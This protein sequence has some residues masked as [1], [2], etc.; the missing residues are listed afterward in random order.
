MKAILYNDLESY[1]AFSYPLSPLLNDILATIQF[2]IPNRMKILVAISE[3]VSFASQF[4]RNIQLP[5]GTGVPINA[6]SFCIAASGAH[7]DSS[8]RA[9]RKVF[10]QAYSFVEEQRETYAVDKAIQAAI[11]AGEELPETREVY[12]AYYQKPTPI[13]LKELT[14]Q[15]LVQYMNDIPVTAHLGAGVVVNS[16]L[17][18]E[19]NT[20]PHFADIIKVLS[21]AYDLGIIEASYTKGKEFRNEGVKGV[22]FNALFIGSYHMLLHNAQIKHKFIDSFMSKLSRRC[23]FTYAPEKLPEVQFTSGKEAIEYDIKI[24]EETKAAISKLEPVMRNVALYHAANAGIAL[25]L[26]NDAD[27]MMLLLKR[28]DSEVA[29]T[30]C[31][32]ESADSLYRKNRYWRVLKLA[33]ALCILHREDVITAAHMAEAITLSE[34]LTNDMAIFEVNLQKAPHERFV[35]YIHT[36]AANGA[37]ITISAHELKKADFIHSVTKQS[38]QALTTLASGYDSF[39]IYTLLENDSKILYEP[40]IK[41]DILQISYKEIDTTL[42]AKAVATKDKDAARVAKG[43]IA[44]TVHNGFEFAEI[45]FVDLGELLVGDYAYSPFQFAHGVR[46]KENIL[47][48]AKWLVLDVDSSVLTAEEVHFLLSDINHHISLSADP[49]NHYKFRVLLELDT[50]VTLSATAW[51]LFYLS[52]AEELGISVDPVPQSQIFYSYGYGTRE[53]LSV[54]TET[55]V[56]TREHIIKAKEREQQKLANKPVLSNAQTKL[57]LKDPETTFAYAFHASNGTASRNIYRMMQHAKELGA[58]YEQTQQLIHEVN[59]Y[60]DVPFTSHRLE[61][62]LDQCNRLFN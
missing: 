20:N 43:Q 40:I 27:I 47:G 60:Y 42:L 39:G 8:L 29:A 3:I 52:V 54:T 48:G 59:Q 28:Y 58:T 33:G 45:T 38:L 7:K 15:G 55:P 35:D 22:A 24:R 53:V 4:R 32:T 30:E 21:E 51:K 57:L 14:P 26:T 50:V 41:T 37:S 11:K 56:E 31:S 23:F 25:P 19:F 61:G 34:F 13:F 16:E 6:I 9:V 2:N 5:E 44:T 18:D 62:L 49:S 10:S 12:E 36:T 46:G 1:K 17:A